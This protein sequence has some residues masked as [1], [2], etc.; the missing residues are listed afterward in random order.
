MKLLRWLG[1]PVSRRKY[2]GK[3]SFRRQVHRWTIRTLRDIL[4]RVDEWVHDQERKIQI[5][6][7]DCRKNDEADLL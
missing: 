5:T 2:P 1:G 3:G 7:S 4:W 6:A